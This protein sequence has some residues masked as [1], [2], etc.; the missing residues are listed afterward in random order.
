M[1][2][3][4]SLV[5][6]MH[7]YFIYLNGRKK[8]NT[9]DTNLENVFYCWFVRS[10]CVRFPCFKEFQKIFDIEGE[11]GFQ[12]WCDFGKKHHPEGVRPSSIG[13]PYVKSVNLKSIVLRRYWS[14]R[15][16]TFTRAY[17]MYVL[18]ICTGKHISSLWSLRSPFSRFVPKLRSFLTIQI[19]WS[20]S[21][22]LMNYNYWVHLAGV[23]DT[24]LVVLSCIVYG[25]LRI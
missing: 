2:R 19:Y 13:V 1:H 25:W 22:P 10:R 24:A 6:H 9:F 8:K 18:S 4:D 20:Q 21:Q 16:E 12:S 14:V 23:A 5:D 7:N 15:A 3:S 11:I 17:Y